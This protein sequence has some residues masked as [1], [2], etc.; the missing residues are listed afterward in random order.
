[1]RIRTIIFLVFPSSLVKAA[2]DG[3]CENDPKFT[4]GNVRKKGC[5]SWFRDKEYRRQN[6]CAN[7]S[8]VR[9]KCKKTC[10][11]CCGDDVRFKFKLDGQDKRK[12]CAWLMKGN[13]ATRDKKRRKYCGKKSGGI[14]VSE[15]W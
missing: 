14:F 5:Y 12:H 3:V 11:L 9:E 7:D 2:G 1:M 4:L 6:I 15:A 10:G 13:K 8:E